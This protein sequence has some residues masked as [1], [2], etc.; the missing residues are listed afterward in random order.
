L[1]RNLRAFLAV[2][3][4]GNLTAAADT[5]GLTQPALTKTIRKLELDFGARLFDRTTRGMVLTPAGSL[6]LER[7]RLIEMHYQHGKEEIRLLKTETLDEFRIAAG[8]AYHAAIAPDLVRKLSIEFPSTRFVLEFKVANHALPKLISGELDLVLGAL[9]MTPSEGIDAE[10]ILRVEITAF[11]C[12]D[13]ALGQAES[14]SR[15]GVSKRTSPTALAGKKWIVYQRDPVM[16]GR[17]RSYCAEYLLPEPQ[18]VMEIDS[19]HASFR[20]ARGTDYLTA[21]ASLLR[22][23][24]EEAGLVMLDLERKIWHFDSGAS[25]RRSLRNYPIMKRALEIVK[26]LAHEFQP[27]HSLKL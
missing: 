26:D 24:A 18:I 9:E 17:L 14:A 12:K 10:P 19:L 15:V 20:A 21:A 5:I 7:S 2:V 23:T 1:D 16:A 22:Q 25:Y 6:L 11:A 3:R 8:I 27:H 4:S 13:S